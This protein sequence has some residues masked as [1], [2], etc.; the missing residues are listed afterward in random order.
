MYQMIENIIREVVKK[1]CQ[2]EKLDSGFERRLEA[3]IK[4]AMQDSASESD[5]MDLLESIPV[6]NL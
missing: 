1:V 6:E 2:E 4:N 5:I 3:L